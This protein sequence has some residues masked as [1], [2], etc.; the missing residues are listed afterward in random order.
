MKKTKTIKLVS[1]AALAAML[2]LGATACSNKESSHET[3]TQS[4][5][6]SSAEKRTDK[7]VGENKT[8]LKTVDIKVSQ[9][10]ALN[11][12]EQ[13][14]GKIQIK[15]IDLKPYGNSYVY[16]IDGFSKEQEHTAE[17]DAHTGKITH[18][19]SEHL[20]LDDRHEKGIDLNGVIS[21]QEASK[22]AEKHAHGTSKEW[23]LEEDNGKTYWDVK[24]SDGTKS[25]DVKIDAHS[26]QVV[27]TEHDDDD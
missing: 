6:Q 11:K 7:V 5:K 1:T 17:I 27:E 22:I 2:C 18:S 8:K 14:F 12:F 10:K 21:R 4:S 25:H 26:K 9:T 13:K 20:D 23:N 15:S 3:T 24:V 19:H 16:E